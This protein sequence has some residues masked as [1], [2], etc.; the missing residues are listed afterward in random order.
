MRQSLPC[1]G[2]PPPDHRLITDRNS[3]LVERQV[4][5]QSGACEKQSICHAFS[6]SFTAR[7][8]ASAVADKLAP[9][10]LEKDG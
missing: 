8:V 2:R 3:S 9:P 1:P 4:E 5:A 7:A 6:Q 10:E